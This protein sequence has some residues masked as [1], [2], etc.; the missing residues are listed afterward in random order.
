[1]NSKTKSQLQ[2]LLG[3]LLLGGLLT[4][5][6]CSSQPVD[7]GDDSSDNGYITPRPLDPGSIAD[8][9]PRVEPRSRYGNPDTYQVF[10]QTYRVMADGRGF[11]ERGMASWYGPKFHGKRTSSGEPYDMYQMTA[12]HKSLPL[13]SYVQVTNLDNGRTAIVRVNDRGP[14]HSKRILDLSYSAAVKLGVVRSGTARV[15]IRAIDPRQPADRPSTTASRILAS[16]TPAGANGGDIYLQAGA[17]ASEVNAQLLHQRL[18]DGLKPQ[19]TVQ[20]SPDPARPLYR[21]RLG[22]LD[23]VETAIRL[24]GQLDQMGVSGARVIVD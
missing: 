13:P 20:T 11:V 21:V 2:R 10:G 24:A 7:Y 3:V 14:F 1:M 23:S 17:F 9:V 19:V 12:A 8:A 15:E 16:N 5:L 18:E 4:L 6:G 22:P